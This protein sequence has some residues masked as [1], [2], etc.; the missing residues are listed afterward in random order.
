MIHTPS[1]NEETSHYSP[2]RIVRHT[3]HVNTGNHT[4][5]ECEKADEMVQWVEGSA[6][7]PADLNS[8][9]GLHVVKGEN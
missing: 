6:A 9:L 5:A 3:K 7:K 1:G 2:H 4:F 8:V